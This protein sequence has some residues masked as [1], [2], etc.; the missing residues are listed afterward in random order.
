MKRV[1]ALLLMTLALPAI[2]FCQADDAPAQQPEGD[3]AE[4]EGQ[5]V[6]LK[7][8]WPDA[9]LTNTSFRVAE[10]LRMQKIVDIFPAPDG[11][12]MAVLRPGEYYVMAVVDANGNNEV[13]AG[14]GF[15]FHG[16]SDLSE[17]SR[18]QPLK[19][20]EGQLNSAKIPILLTRTEDGR[21]TPL[22]AT[23][24]RTRGTLTGELKGV[25]GAGKSILL[26]AL[27]VEMDTRP[28][29]TVVGAD[30]AYELRVPA[31]DHT[32]VALTDSDAS[33]TVTAGDIL[34]TRGYG[35]TEPVSVEADA[36]ATVD[37]MDISADCAVPAELPPVIAGRITSAEVPDSGQ[38][39][40]AFC[41][42][43]GL[44]NEAFSVAAGA[45]G[46]FAAVPQ[47]GTYYLR[48]T[49]DRA[50]DSKL[51]VGDMMGF[52]GVTDLFEE[53]P[54]SLEVT[55]G[56]LL[57]D[58]EIP[59]SAYINEDGRLSTWTGAENEQGR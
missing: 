32:L 8:V 5:V 11:T 54:A 43:R 2:A 33:G 3:E 36:T 21:L 9:D 52:Y 47:P 10:D 17:G 34:A 53:Q 48:A 13:D 55:E 4:T 20:E 42:D 44:R 19:V 49:I 15:G 50:A 31:G 6:V 51:G 1:I 38:A 45:D 26:L 29:V 58:L 37:P 25:T 14:D 39:S 28:V 12:A 56:M 57:T 27:P 46:V 30:G 7:A 16:V 23:R 22:T 35:G 18:P 24:E 41:T 59:I 40:V